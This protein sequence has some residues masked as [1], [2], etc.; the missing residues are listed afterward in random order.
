MFLTCIQII[1]GTM[2]FS[3]IHATEVGFSVLISLALLV[4][5]T[6]AIMVIGHIKKVV[7]YRSKLLRRS[8][9]VIRTEGVLW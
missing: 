4:L 5:G 6:V 7:K 2:M 3:L 1:I 9:K 8:S